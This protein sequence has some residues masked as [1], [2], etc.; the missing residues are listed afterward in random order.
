MEKEELG[1]EAAALLV[2]GVVPSEKKSN[3]ADSALFDA[4]VEPASAA[5]GN[6]EGDC[7]NLEG[8]ILV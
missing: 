4:D 2:E 6:T 5:L 8:C 7:S 1:A 3:G